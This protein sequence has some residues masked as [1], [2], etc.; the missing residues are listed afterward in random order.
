MLKVQALQLFTLVS[1][2]TVN[3]FKKHKADFALALLDN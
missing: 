1:I 3:S 2:S